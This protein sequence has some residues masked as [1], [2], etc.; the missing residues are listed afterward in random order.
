MNIHWLIVCFETRLPVA[1]KTTGLKLKH[2]IT[3]AVYLTFNTYS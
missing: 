1:Q 3:D 2:L